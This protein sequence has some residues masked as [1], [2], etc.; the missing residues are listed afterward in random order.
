MLQSTK[1]Y[2]AAID[3]GSNSCRL[4]VVAQDDQ[5]LR[6]IDA[7]SRIT[8][9]SEGVAST[10]LINEE[11]QERTLMTLRHALK[12]LEARTPF[13]IRCVAT[14]VCR[15]ARNA[16][17]F[18]NHIFKETRLHFSVISE[19]E[20]ARLAVMG[21][22]PLFDKRYPYALTF[23]IGGG[24]TEAVL[25]KTHP[26]HGIPEIID[27]VSIP[28][29]V[30]SVLETHNPESCANYLR[31][32]ELIRERLL[33]FGEPYGLAELIERKKVQLIGASGTATTAASL[34]LGMRYYDRERIDGYVIS[35]ADI[36]A[37]IKKLQMMSIEERAI[38][39]CIGPE[40]ADL[41]LGGMAIFEGL[42]STWPIGEITV[43]DRG[44]RDGLIVEMTSE[45]ALMPKFSI[46]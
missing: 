38:H 1:P 45:Q 32:I 43:A 26:P 41:V 23:D 12:R 6:P 21:L 33:S 9:L 19:E 39:P 15:R 2:Y 13:K 5:G 8:R 36:E 37:V 34:H 28:L 11:A 24:S 14:E 40:R 10:G 18:L 42:S 25:V 22:L 16:D 29:G 46:A 35:V 20:E 4:L 7:Y 3:L 44:V 30:V 27:W 17:A 31:I